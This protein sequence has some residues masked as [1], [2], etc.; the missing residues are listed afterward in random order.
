MMI[1]IVIG[2]AV[3]LVWCRWMDREYGPSESGP[4]LKTRFEKKTQYL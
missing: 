2:Y 1:V 3:V 4:I